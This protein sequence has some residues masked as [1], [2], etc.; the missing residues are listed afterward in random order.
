MKLNK[1]TLWAFLLLVVTASLFRVWQ[2]RPAGFVPHIAMAIFGGAIITDKKNMLG[3][4]LPLLSIFFSD[5]LYEIL[6]INGVS[7]IP[8]FY[9]GQVINYF[10]FLGLTFLGSLMKRINLKNVIGFSISGSVLFFIASNFAVWAGHGGLKRPMTFD[11]LMLCYGDAIAYYRDFGLIQ[12]FVGNQIL[13][14]L[15]FGFLLFG[16]YYLIRKY[17]SAYQPG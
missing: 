15:F 11:G 12:G 9:E 17:T 6:W 14:D 10:L 7:P 5:V 3:Y 8:G 16:C 4:F 2:G 13:G 1:S